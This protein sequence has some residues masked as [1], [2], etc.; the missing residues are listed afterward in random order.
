MKY[1]VFFILGVAFAFSGCGGT[2]LPPVHDVPRS[3]GVFDYGHEACTV[4]Y[5]GKISYTVPSGPF[6]P[7][8]IRQSS[9]P[10]A[11]LS[12]EPN[13]SLPAWAHP[14]GS[15]Q[16][17]FV[18][19]SLQEAY[20]LAGMQSIETVAAAHHVP[21]SWMINNGQYL[22]NAGLYNAYHIANGDD[23]EVNNTTAAIAQAES[24]FT[25][26]AP[27]VSVEG[28]GH[29]RDIA[30]DLQQ[31][32][33]AFWGITWN[34]HGIDSTADY[35]S[36]WGAYCADTSS[37]KRPSPDGSCAMLAFEW[38]A[39][40][41][42]RAYLSGHEEYF[43]TDPDDLQQRAGFSTVG[44]QQYARALVDAYAAAGQSQPIVMMSQQESAE[45]LNLGDPQIL[46]ALYGEAVADGMRTVTL[47]QA[48]QLARTAAAQPRA[49]AFP[50]I[51]GGK[52]LASLIDGGLL[53]PATIDYHDSTSGM[54]FLSGHT[55]PTRVFRY[56]DNPRS[57][58]DIPL[59]TVPIAELPTLSSVAVNNGTILFHFQAPSAMHYGVALWS[60]PSALRITGAGVTAA[61]SAGVVLTF[62]LHAGPND[63]SFACAGCTGTT[64]PYST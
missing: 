51:P 55:Q 15:T 17:L 26:Y 62:D 22:L 8:D 61:G 5:D 25:W 12:S 1:R 46:D 42:T 13:A 27:A 9:C 10:P 32:E 3:S 23:V 58:F 36:P 33:N 40:D 16:A 29:E 48:A 45:D 21:V 50:Y 60:N 49:V 37:Y 31:G 14:T 47:R 44:A 7:I 19:T 41:L 2:A 18:A 56:A 63:V 57:V 6:S 28:A 38:T 24:A 53:Y 43:S 11:A 64:F 30:A 59:A 20:S 4:S 35:G 34:S 39:R 54:T 52:T